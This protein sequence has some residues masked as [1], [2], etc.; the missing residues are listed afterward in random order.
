[1]FM[2]IGSGSGSN[3]CSWVLSRPIP[4][5]PRAPWPMS[6]AWPNRKHSPAGRKSCSLTS[7]LAPVATLLL[8]PL[9]LLLATHRKSTE[10]PDERRGLPMSRR[11]IPGLGRRGAGAGGLCT[12]SALLNPGAPASAPA[13]APAP[14][15]PAASLASFC[16]AKTEETGKTRLFTAHTSAVQRQRELTTSVSWPGLGSNNYAR[17]HGH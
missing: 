16:M 10:P 15:G 7:L 8:L 12:Q 11:R 13:P 6:L 1:M 5:M 4:G 17:S 9:L 14:D 3:C 2:A